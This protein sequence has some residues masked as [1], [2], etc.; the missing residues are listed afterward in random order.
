M[1]EPTCPSCSAMKMRTYEIEGASKKSSILLWVSIASL[2]LSI[3]SFIA[4]LY[5]LWMAILALTLY[6]AHR[7]ILNKSANVKL[8]ELRCME[9]GWSDY[10]PAANILKD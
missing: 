1:A 5:N 6:I 3:T 7:I 10:G 2:I 4:I 8:V 9:C